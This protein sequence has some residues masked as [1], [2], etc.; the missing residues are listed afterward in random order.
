MRIDFHTPEG[1]RWA[2]VGGVDENGDPIEN[3]WVAAWAAN[4]ALGTEKADSGQGARYVMKLAAE[5]DRYDGADG[6]LGYL[7]A[8]A[9]LLP[10]ALLVFETAPAQ[11]DAVSTLSMLAGLDGS[12]PGA[13]RGPDL[14]VPAASAVVR[15]DRTLAPERK[16]MFG[17]TPERHEARW[18]LRVGPQDVLLTL[19]PV[20][21]EHL[22]QAV[23]D[24]EA[25]IGTLTV[26]DA[27]D[28]PLA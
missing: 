18:A 26:T 16:G 13:V 4:T 23:A 25:L 3:L 8:G 10:P 19:G 5:L 6:P 9:A 17:K 12:I 28:A 24:A 7:W 22:A 11:G 20:P 15:S 1:S 27:E 2:M 14:A 21:P